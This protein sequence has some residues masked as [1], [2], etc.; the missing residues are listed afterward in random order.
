MKVICIDDSNR[1]NEVK[2][3]N[4]VKKDKDYTVVKLLY[5]PIQNKRFFVLEEVQ[6]DPPYGGYAIERFG[7]PVPEELEELEEELVYN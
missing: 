1:P 2:L 7:I 3:T 4:W 5:N 6:P